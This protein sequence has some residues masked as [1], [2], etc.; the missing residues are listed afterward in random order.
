MAGGR[1][2]V[3]DQVENVFEDSKFV[4]QV[5]VLPHGPCCAL[6]VTVAFCARCLSTRQSLPPHLSFWRLLTLQRLRT[7]SPYRLSAFLRRTVLCFFGERER[8]LT[9]L[10]LG[11]DFVLRSVP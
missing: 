11:V 1:V 10:V 5:P 8:L 4:R 7:G 9:S 2:I 3:P 6:L